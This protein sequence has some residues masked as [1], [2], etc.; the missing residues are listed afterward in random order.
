MLLEG[1]SGLGAGKSFRFLNGKWSKISHLNL[2]KGTLLFGEFVEE[3]CTY[4]SGYEGFEKRYSLHVV[5]ANRLG[6]MDLR[7]YTYLERLARHLV[8]LHLYTDF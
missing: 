3:I 5:D 2:V 7:N 8:N 1:F 4:H 6:D